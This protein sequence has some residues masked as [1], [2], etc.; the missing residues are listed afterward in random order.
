MRRLTT[1]VRRT[2]I[3]LAAVLV[4]SVALFALD[5][6][7]KTYFGNLAIDGYDPVAYFTDGKPVPGAKEWTQAW[8]GANWRFA[9]QEHRDLFAANPGKYAPQYG[10]YCAW[11]VSQ[12]YTADVDPAAWAIVDDKLYLNYDLEIRSKWMAQQAELITKADANWPT[13]LA[14]KT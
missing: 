10:G 1:L 2:L 14:G 4:S 8:Q 7:N 13:L 9:T 12:G 3:G 6:V 5:P 11:A